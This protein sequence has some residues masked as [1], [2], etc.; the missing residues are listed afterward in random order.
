MP[1]ER[2]LI[3]VETAANMA[4]I[5]K[6]KL[7]MLGLSGSAIALGAVLGGVILVSKDMIDIA[8][9]H[10]EAEKSLAQA[11]DAANSEYGKTKTVVP[12][13]TKQ[14]KAHDAA[15]RHLAEVEAGMP[16]KHKATRLELMHLQDA[17]KRVRETTLA[18]TAAQAAGS[19]QVNKNIVYLAGY[20]AQID[21][22]IK[23]NREY[24]SD[25]SEVI[26]NYAKL[27]RAGLAVTEVQRVM[28]DA[29][30]LSALK[31]ISLSEAVDLL[32]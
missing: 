7:G 27:T 11:V 2:V 18:L 4:G 3:A 13:V 8:T 28:N 20:R 1:T 22:F 14:V 31:H 24:I 9:K 25:Q 5:E 12:D 10:E 6:A 15:V 32:T 17:H 21:Q 23:S 26:T 16:T 30:N 29:V 19:T